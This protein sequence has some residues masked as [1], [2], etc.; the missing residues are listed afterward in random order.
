MEPEPEAL[1]V[2]IWGPGYFGR[3]W[4]HEV[5]RNSDCNLFGVISRSREHVSGLMRELSLDRLP[6]FDGPVAARQAGAEAVIVTV[7][8]MLHRE[9][10]IAALDAG[11]HLILEKPLAMTL[12]EGRAIAKRAAALPEQVVMVTQNFRWR[13]HALALRKAVQ[14]GV[15]GRVSNVFV[16]CRQAIKRSTTEAW[17]ERMDDPY[18]AD[19]AIHHFDLMRYLTGLEVEEVFATSYRPASSW[20]DGRSAAAALLKMTGGAV[21]SY[22]GTMV[23]T[24]ALTTQEGL[25]T[26]V[27]DAGALR[28]DGKYQVV[29][30]GAGE[31]ITLPEPLVPDGELAHGLREFVDAVRTKRRPETHVDDNFRSFAALMAAMES[32][33]TGKPVKVASA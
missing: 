33:A 1:R 22:H 8:Q 6:A 25:I 17:R 2:V 13:P 19:F 29:L 12:D 3:K 28:L 30:L 15:I 23:A 21:A 32:A 7:P 9:A 5:Q 16:E 31:P 20:F 14:G 18:L 11:L 4:L 27:G 26:L 10:A 24:G